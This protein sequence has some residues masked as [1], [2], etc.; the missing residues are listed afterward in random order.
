MLYLEHMYGVASGQFMNFDKSCIYCSGNVSAEQK[1]VLQVDM[2]IQKSLRD[3]NYLGLSL[4]LGRSKATYEFLRRIGVIVFKVSLGLLKA[5][6]VLMKGGQWRIRNG[7]N[8]LIMDDVWVVG[9][10]DGKVNM[11]PDLLNAPRERV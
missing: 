3:C 11:L 9:S 6:E 4:I 5:R 1:K 10:P 8:V 7:L 2:G